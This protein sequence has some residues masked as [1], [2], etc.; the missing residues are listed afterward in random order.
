MTDLPAQTSPASLLPRGCALALVFILLGGW[1]LLAS[2]IMIGWN[3]VLEQDLMMRVLPGPDRRGLLALGFGLAVCIPAAVVAWLVRGSAVRRAARV[4][5]LGGLLALFLA[6]SRLAGIQQSQLSAV[7][8]L[9][10]IAAFGIVIG[11]VERSAGRRLPLPSWAGLG[12][13]LAIGAGLGVPWVLWGALGSPLDTLLA[14]LVSLCTAVC[15]T[16]VWVVGQPA[17]EVPPAY[18]PF[19]LDG[20]LGSLTLLPVC[21]VLGANGSAAMLA[22]A[23]PW[24]AWP[25]A[26]L[27][28]QDRQSSRSSWPAAALLIA[29][30]LFWP[31]A[32]VDLEEL[33]IL[34]SGLGEASRWIWTAGSLSAVLSAGSVVLAALLLRFWLTNR[35]LRTAGW[36]L[37]GLTWIILLVVYFFYGQP[38]F[39]GERLFVILKNQADLTFAAAISDPQERRAEVYTR[40][41]AHADRTQASLRTELETLGIDFTSYYL[42][43]A[44][45]VQGDPLLAGWLEAR[46]EVDRVLIDTRLR[47]LPQPSSFRRRR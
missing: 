1:N 30:G 16:L 37:G 23:V 24:L 45:E 46:P 18:A 13:A 5:S 7:L 22:L 29:L 20:L 26:G 27:I 35:I 41:V 28:N 8:Q 9:M 3:G 38:G 14:L 43:N 12:W 25:A 32:C 2:A 21:A 39:Y 47:P 34:L 4:L 44:I 19:L 33:S 42:V 11:L 15:F 10:G 36:A 17:G 31:L 6:P 40:L